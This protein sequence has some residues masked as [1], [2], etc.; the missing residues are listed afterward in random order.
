MNEPIRYLLV[1]H[2][3]FARSGDAVELDAL[4]LRDLEGLR[5]SV[6]HVTVAAPQVASTDLRGWGPGIASVRDSDRL[7]FIGFPNIRGRRD[8]PRWLGVR[9]ILRD[10]VARAD[11]VHTSNLF[12]PYLGLIYAHQ[13]A[14]KM[15]KK[16]VFVIAEDFFDML[17]WEWG[18]LARGPTE[19]WSRGRT[20]RRLDSRAR[21]SAA[22]A[23]LTFV[24]TPA[25]VRRY[26][27]YGRN[28]IAI[29]LPAHELGDVISQDALEARRNSMMNGERLIVV[30]AGRHSALKGFDFL[31]MAAAILKHRG[32]DIDVRIYGKG[33]ETAQLKSLSMRLGVADRVS[34]PG[35][36]SPGPAI[37]AAISAG[38]LSA[39]PHR[40][41]DFGRSFYDAMAG[42]T[43]VVAFRTDAS[44]DTVREGIDGWICPLD[45]VEAL[46]ATLERLNRCRAMVAAASINARERALRESKSFWCDLRAQAIRGLFE[47]AS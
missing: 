31:I 6:G 35:G 33:A 38:H 10:A 1:T 22:T 27:L 36:L 45:D 39:M 34:L 20:L 47:E 23:S 4:W 7:E 13:R 28:V 44:I 21:R 12:P 15:G 16:T 9:R 3:P 14:L 8:L 41:T 40:T 37:Y 2:I 17:S 42:G 11:L 32:V 18:R 29:R 19:Q 5:D 26:R 25:A 24:H 43:P 30:A 46:A